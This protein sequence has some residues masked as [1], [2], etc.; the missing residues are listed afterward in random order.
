MIL[1]Q[2]NRRRIPL[3]R[4]RQRLTSTSV[5][6]DA[7]SLLIAYLWYDH[8]CA[9]RRSRL[10]QHNILYFRNHAHRLHTSSGLLVYVLFLFCCSSTCCS[11]SFGYFS[12][13]Q[14]AALFH[15]SDYFTPAVQPLS[16]TSV[17][18]SLVSTFIFSHKYRVPP[19]CVSWRPFAT[20][21]IHN[22]NNFQV[23]Y[24]GR[25]LMSFLRRRSHPSSWHSAPFQY[26]HFQIH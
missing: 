26:N 5:L 11:S 4:E 18:C 14:F 12:A 13:L 7:I 25:V 6:S 24:I 23:I 9:I 19:V 17:Y 20:A 22:R 15:S 21:P 10:R 8:S 2:Q 1:G 16:G 3:A